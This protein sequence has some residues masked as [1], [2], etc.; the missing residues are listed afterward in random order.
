MTISRLLQ[1]AP[2]TLMLIGMFIAVA[3]YQW[4]A[5]VQ[6]DAPSTRDLLRFG[7]DFLPLSMIDEPWR[8]ISSGF[9][10]IGVLHLLFNGFAMYYF[11][12]VVEL[13][14]GSKLFIAV[15]LLSV[16]GGNL[17][18]NYTAWQGVLS[19]VMPPVSAGASGGIMGLGA[20]LLVLAVFKTPIGIQLNTRSLAM[21]MAINLLMGFAIDGID[22][23][24]HIGG[25]VSGLLL[26][27]CYAYLRPRHRQGSMFWVVAVMI[28]GF[29]LLWYWLHGHVLQL[30]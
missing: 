24:G 28:A 19:G 4:L 13:V 8:L 11:G 21:I 26:G 29:G 27:L 2:V 10:H 3:G 20:F 16:V 22:N 6:I 25:A 5:G 7:A 12:Q 18:G 15:F 14:I 23:A 1:T 17:L 30:I 9:V